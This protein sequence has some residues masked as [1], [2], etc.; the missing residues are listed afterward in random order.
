MYEDVGA[1]EYDDSDDFMSEE[2]LEE[3]FSELS[4][5]KD[6]IS[7]KTFKQWDEIQ[8]LLED[9]LIAESGNSSTHICIYR[10]TYIHAH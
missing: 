4:G 1:G 10:Q 8:G 2:E 3:E 7:V 6:T 9:E 5:G